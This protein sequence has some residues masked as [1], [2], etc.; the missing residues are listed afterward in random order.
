MKKFLLTAGFYLLISSFLMSQDKSLNVPYNVVF[1]LTSGDTIQHRVVLRWI[2]LISETNP[3]AR[4][5]LVVYGNA[6]PVFVKGKSIAG[7]EISRLAA[8]KKVNFRACAVTMKRDN[9]TKEQLVPGVETVPDAIYE[10]I[11]RQSEGWGYIKVSQ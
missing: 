5:E 4:L 6:L 1:D 2:K 3:D 7:N 11:S 10:I 8:G 9:I